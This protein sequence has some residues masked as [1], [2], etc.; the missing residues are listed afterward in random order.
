MKLLAADYDGTFKS[1]LKN[2]RINI[3]KVNEFM[4]QG[5]KFVIITGRSFKQIEPEIKKYNIKYNYLIC[6][7]GLIIFDNDNKIINYNLLPQNDLEFIYSSLLRWYRIKN[8]EAYSYLTTTLELKEVLEIHGTFYN[9]FHASVYKKNLEYVRNYLHCYQDK[10][11]L[12]ISL[13]LNKS[14]SIKFIQEK[15]NLDKEQI[16]TVGDG[17]ND[18]EMLLEFN[19]YKMLKCDKKLLFKKIPT[20]YQ[21]HKL[22]DKIK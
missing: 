1:N 9:E 12:F 18:I 16:F 3:N 20:T 15:E 7:N 8:V 19:G 4:E 14:D 17:L 11:N 2:L 22:I 13:N 6:N 10:N 21:V 5:N